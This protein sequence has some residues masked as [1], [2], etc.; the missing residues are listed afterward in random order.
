MNENE[1]RKRG[2]AQRDGHP[3]WQ[4]FKKIGAETAEK[5][6][7]EIKKLDVKYNGQ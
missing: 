7:L 1:N 2:K 5:Q 6:Y 3:V 4:S